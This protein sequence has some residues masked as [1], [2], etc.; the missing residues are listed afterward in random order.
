VNTPN[1]PGTNYGCSISLDLP[2]SLLLDLKS[3]NGA[4]TVLESQN[5]VECSTSNGAITIE[6]TNGNVKLKTSNGEITAR[7]HYGELDAKTSNGT[8]DADVVLPEGGDCFLKTSNGKIYL[9]VP[10][11]TSAMIEAST[12]NGGIEID[13]IALTVIS[14]EKKKDLKGKMGDGDGEIRLETSNGSIRI[15]GG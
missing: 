9:S 14:M 1:R 7:N 10:E 5:S 2:A 6:D 11:E 15:T 8:I 3:S 13:N 12:S 4:I